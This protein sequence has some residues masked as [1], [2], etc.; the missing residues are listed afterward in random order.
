MGKNDTTASVDEV[1]PDSN[2]RLSPPPFAHLPAPKWSSQPQP[3]KESQIVRVSMGIFDAALCLMPISLMV[4]IGL[5]IFADHKQ[6]EDEYIFIFGFGLHPLTKFL[7]EINGQV[8]A[9]T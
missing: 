8:S 7:I 4:K 5:C 6:K 3:L 2:S 1:E 9:S